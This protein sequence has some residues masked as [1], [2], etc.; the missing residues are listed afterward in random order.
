M[1]VEVP[2]SVARRL[3]RDIGWEP[4][5]MAQAK[6]GFRHGA[7]VGGARGVL[8]PRAVC[9]LLE[10]TGIDGT[11]D[12]IPQPAPDRTD[13]PEASARDSAEPISHR[14]V[15]HANSLG[16]LHVGPRLLILL[17][18]APV[19]NGRLEVLPD[20]FDVNVQGVAHFK[21]A[22]GLSRFSVSFPL[23]TNVLS[24]DLPSIGSRKPFLRIRSS[25]SRLGP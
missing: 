14:R 19:Q 15:V 8:P 16:D 2:W 10:A 24:A 7:C 12:A 13:S 3:R 17:G 9:R 18:K 23:S 4:K 11:K 21:V 1:A 25:D 6:G 5:P 22:A 20:V